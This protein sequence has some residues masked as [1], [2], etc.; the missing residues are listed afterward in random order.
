MK[1]LLLS[2]YDS[3]G[4]S[5]RVRFQQYL[6]YLEKGG[7]AV[8]PMPLFSDAYVEAF[9]ADAP[10]A[11][12]V[13]KGY[14][15]RVNALI[16]ARRFDVVLLEKEVF[17]FLPAV[18]ERVLRRLGIPYVV[19]YDDAWF[20][21]YDLHPKAWVR[22]VLGRKIDTVMRHSAAVVAGNA[23]LAERARAAGARR[24]EVIPTVVDAT[25]YAPFTK[26]D[27]DPLVIGWIGTPKT[28]HYLQRLLPLFERL[29]RDDPRLRVVAVGGGED[30]FKGTPVQTWA[31]SA[32]TEV[33]A[34]QQFD[35]GIMPLD[36]GLWERGKCGY[37][38][39][40]YMACGKPV[41]ASPVGVNVDIVE[42]RACGVLAGDTGQWY[43]ALR[44][45]LD[46][47][48]RRRSLGANG[49]RAVEGYYSVQAQ[50]PR[51]SAVL[52]QAA[53]H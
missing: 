49:R 12:E 19:D 28:S 51:L 20:H 40:Q 41:V 18:V 3:R 46:D 38:L 10:R 1:V 45:L 2:R 39:I 16:R 13:L 47:P 23:Y 33:S 9:Y 26:A 53:A 6:P 52:R 17:P 27:T 50:A 31:W 22:R 4:A 14:L 11:R 24:I 42:G 36:D 37:K 43:G 48:A 25:C 35:V 8:T 7:I 29:R 15:K 30:A 21:R 34:V 32:E 5:S 44:G